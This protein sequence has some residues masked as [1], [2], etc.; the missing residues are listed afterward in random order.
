[1][2]S[3]RTIPRPLPPPRP[4]SPSREYVGDEEVT[5]CT[6]RDLLLRA[7]NE[8]FVM[9]HS[10]GKLAADVAEAKA[11]AMSASAAASRVETA[12]STEK[13][14][15]QTA[16]AREAHERQ[17]SF[18]DLV[19]VVDKKLAEHKLAVVEDKAEDLEKAIE[20]TSERRWA[21]KLAVITAVVVAV[22][23]AV[24]AT[25]VRFT[26]ASIRGHW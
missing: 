8:I 3:E 18:P 1:M 9:Q 25:V 14:E 26:E 22:V 11:A 4:R 16:D 19:N 24:G 13:T 5:R 2:A 12:L 17:E 7:L 10:I 6:D 21:V 20:K 15:R 23:T